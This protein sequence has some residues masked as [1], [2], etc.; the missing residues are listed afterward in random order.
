MQFNPDFKQE[1]ENTKIETLKAPSSNLDRNNPDLKSSLTEEQLFGKEAVDGELPKLTQDFVILK[2]KQ[3]KLIEMGQI[4]QEVY[5]TK[6]VSRKQVLAIESLAR[7]LVEQKEERTKVVVDS[8]EVNM[9]TEE[10]SSVEVETVIE[11]SR[12]AVDEI[13]GNLKN[14]TTELATK[15][16]DTIDKDRVSRKDNLQNSIA[17]FNTSVI[18]FLTEKDKDTFENVDF[19]FK[20]NLK[21][22]DLLSFELS[23]VR[24]S[25]SDNFERIISSFDGTAAESFLKTLIGYF[26]GSNNSYNVV[27]VFVNGV[28]AVVP[29]SEIA[30]KIINNSKEENSLVKYR[31]TVGDLLAAFGDSRFNKFYTHLESIIE[32]NYNNIKEL[33]ESIIKATK[34]E[35]LISLSN[36]INICHKNILD[37]TGNMGVLNYIQLMIVKLLKSF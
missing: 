23:A 31:I 29:N 5:Q 20:R 2:S 19:K 14:S 24:Y 37:C 36:C 1:L 27:R 4:A 33:K 8:H 11:N 34:V 18:E 28:S 9:F 35:D 12:V 17:E 7:D 26:Q 16:I 21:F 13:V 15:I 25:E 6:K 22:S 10:P 3:D 30:E 32:E